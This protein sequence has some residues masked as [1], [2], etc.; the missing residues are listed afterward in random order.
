MLII[1]LLCVVKA[2][3]AAA[4]NEELSD[5]DYSGNYDDIDDDYKST[6]SDEVTD[7]PSTVSETI[8]QTIDLMKS[9]NK[10]TT[11]F[12][13][14]ASSAPITILVDTTTP[15]PIEQVCPE[16]CKCN[17]E[18]DSVDCSNQTL[19]QIPKNLPRSTVQLNL[20]HNLLTT[21][22]IS[23]LEN[24]KEL[25]QLF[26]NDN[27]I[28][29]IVNTDRFSKLPSLHYI[30][31]SANVLKP[32][33]GTEFKEAKALATLILA[34][35]QNV[36]QPDT[37]IVQAHK[38][39]TLNLANCSIT[40]FS[41]NVFQNVSS[42]FLLDLENNPIDPELNFKAFKYLRNLRHLNIPTISRTVVKDLCSLL[43]TID[44]LHLTNET[45]DFSCF[46]YTSGSEFEDST[47]RVGQPT[48]S[49]SDD[50]ELYKIM[51]NPPPIRMA[52]TQKSTKN[53]KDGKKHQP[54]EEPRA[55][56]SEQTNSGLSQSEIP[57][58][59]VTNNTGSTESSDDPEK[60]KV[61]IS[62]EVIYMLL[63][64]LIVV[65]LAALL[66]GVFCRLDCC[67][68]KTKCCRRQHNRAE[69]GD[70]VQPHEAIPLKEV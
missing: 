68:I 46:L 15:E 2:S 66:I 13:T 26:V 17:S 20:S 60:A 55:Q 48:L 33:N 29:I 19:V 50:E 14:E 44:I 62:Q 70:R 53:Y 12:A 11:Q 1:L 61:N 54:I 36:V 65:T 35:N 9:T 27:Q 4:T 63:I 25:E 56:S 23:N 52:S 58:E 16:G 40:K 38:L 8:T 10:S 5:D 24:L 7:T 59:R 37:P 28:E 49:N 3:F 41:D 34:G 39:Q 64:G 31:L 22:N 47:I 57:T 30:D 6:I 42:L 21:L 67:G 51:T 32:L 18:F 45:Y 69:S 43:D